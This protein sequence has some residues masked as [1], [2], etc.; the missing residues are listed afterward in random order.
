M[1]KACG[2]LTV[3]VTFQPP[4]GADRLVRMP[5]LQETTVRFSGHETFTL[6]YGWLTKAVARV[7]S[8]RRVFTREDAMVAFGVGKNMVRSIRHWSMA[9][10]VNGTE[11]FVSRYGEL[12]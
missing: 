3:S 1:D 10:G 7:R 5:L 6:R 8:D 9:S 4:N 12:I 11:I 2:I